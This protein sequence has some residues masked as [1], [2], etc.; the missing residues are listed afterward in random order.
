MSERRELPIEHGKQ[1]RLGW[2]ENEVVEAIIAVN[3]RRA[4]VRR[5]VMRQPIDQA[6]HRID[7]LGLR[8]LVLPAPAI[9]LPR[10]VVARLAEVAQS[11]V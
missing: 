4:F 3:D 2:M 11:R 10:E 9:D 7:R 5:N 6:I 1:L 8:G